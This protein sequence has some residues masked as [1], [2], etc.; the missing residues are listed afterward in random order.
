MSAS[1]KKKVLKLP[2]HVVAECAQVLVNNLTVDVQEDPD[3]EYG[4][5]C[6]TK[7]GLGHLH[8]VICVGRDI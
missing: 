2:L 7:S 8:T 5:S 1:K 6:T 3:T 4:M